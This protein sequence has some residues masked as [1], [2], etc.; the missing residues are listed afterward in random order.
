MAIVMM[1][2]TVASALS[3]ANLLPYYSIN[4]QPMQLELDIVENNV[5][6]VQQLER[7]AMLENRHL[8]L[9]RELNSTRQRERRRLAEVT[10][11]STP[12]AGYL[13]ELLFALKDISE[14]HNTHWNS[15]QTAAQVAKSLWD[16]EILHVHLRKL[17]CKYLR[18]TFFTPFNILREMD[19][20]GGTLSY[21]GIDASSG[22]LRG[23]ALQRIHYPIEVGDQKNGMLKSTVHS[24]RR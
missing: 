17:A 18:G 15:Y 10:D 19:L 3:G 13:G 20:V 5:V 9:S 4:N 16:H 21:E 2:G 7:I 12:A 14:R 1:D 22:D 6:I 23:Q 24:A 8:M 11:T